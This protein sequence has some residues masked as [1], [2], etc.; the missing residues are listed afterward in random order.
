MGGLALKDVETVRYSREDYLKIKE[1]VL[2]K[3]KPYFKDV[4]VPYSYNNKETFGDLDV[5]VCND[6]METH[7]MQTVIRDNFEANEVFHNDDCWSFDH[8]KFQIDVIFAPEKDFHSRFMYMSYNDLG[9]LLGVIAKGFGVKYGNQGLTKDVY[10]K[11]QKVAK[12]L[13][14]SKDHRKIFEFLGVSYE[15]W[16]EGFDTLEEIFGFVYESPYFRKSGYQFDELNKINRDRNK[17]RSSYMKFL[18]WLE[19][20]PE[21]EYE[22]KED[23]D[24]YLDYIDKFFPESRIKEK[25]REAEFK[26]AKKLYIASKVNVGVILDRLALPKDDKHGA[27][28]AIVFDKYKRKLGSSKNLEEHIIHTDSRKLID[29]EIKPMIRQHFKDLGESDPFKD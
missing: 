12:N 13:L 1:E 27:Q 18:E 3:L 21:K 10:Y 29:K 2:D 6:E 16:K 26:R 7:D 5:V 15:R 25:V 8:K 20:K 24:Q 4:A 23:K 28:V 14:I 9:N 19:K 22:F 11:G 17:K